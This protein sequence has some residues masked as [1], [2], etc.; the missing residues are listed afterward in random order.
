MTAVTSTSA[1]PLEGVRI[2]AFTQL[3]AGPYGM[4]VLADLG[5]EI[6]KI[7]DPTGGGDE[8]RNVPPFAENGD[9]L[10]F[11]A[12]NRSAKSLTLNLRS[13]AARAVLHRLVAVSDAVYANCRGDLPAKLGLTYADLKGVNPRIVCCTLSGFGTT[14]PRAA[15]PAYDYLLQGLAGFMSLTGDPNG[16]P[17]KCGVSVV[18]YSGGLMSIVGLLVCL[19]RAR[20]TGTGGDVDVSLLDTAMSML[21]YLASWNLTRGVQPMR[22]ADSAHP[23][24]VPSQTFATRD[25][26]MLVMCMKEKF[27]QRMVELIE[28]PELADDPRFRTFADRL[29]HRDELIPLLKARFAE[30][31]TAEWLAILHGAVPCGPIASVAEALRNP[32][33]QARQM[34]VSFEHPHFGT[35]RQIGCAIKIDDTQPRYRAAP[36]VGADTDALLRDLLAL[37][38]TEIAELRECGAI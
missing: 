29:A 23:S 6:V 12:F 19:L 28:R 15:E 2:L 7:E 27:W 36:A 8:A 21:N 24:V 1:L 30:K 10:F 33:V 5:A 14:G 22:L 11:Q 25:G 17:T 34:V 20:A 31:T 38:D 3:G 18:D 32:Q 35:V 13:P 37:S 16:P 26:Y 4:T 9:S